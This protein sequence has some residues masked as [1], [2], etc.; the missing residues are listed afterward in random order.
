MEKPKSSD[1]ADATEIEVSTA[2]L[3]IF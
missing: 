1:R 2:K 3:A